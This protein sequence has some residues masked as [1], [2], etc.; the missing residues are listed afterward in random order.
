M[1]SPVLARLFR[2]RLWANFRSW[3]G[4][5]CRAGVLLT[6]LLVAGVACRNTERATDKLAAD[7][8]EARGSSS[9]TLSNITLEQPDEK[10]TL[11]WRVKA[12]QATYDRQSGLAQVENPR[13][14]LFQ[15][16]KVV[17]RLEAERADVEQDGERIF[18]RGK[19]TAIDIQDQAVLRGNEVEWRPKEDILVVRHQLSGTHPQLDIKAQEARAYS[20]KRRIELVG[21]IVAEAKNPVLQ[22]RAERAIW[23]LKQEQLTIGDQ[24]PLLTPPPPA[25]GNQTRSYRLIEIDR[26]QNEQDQNEQVTDR[27]RAQTAIVDLKRKIATLKQNV[28][29]TLQEPPLDVKGNLLV[30]QTQQQQVLADQ[31]VQIFHRQDRINLT[32]NRG[33]LDLKQEVATLTGNV[34]G[35]EPERQAKLRADRL[36][37][38]IPTQQMEAIGNVSYQ[39]ADPPLNLTGPRATGKFKD[40]AQTVVV[41]GGR[42]VTEIVPE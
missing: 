21:A 24:L 9:L 37:W 30:W 35:M 26:Y 39:Q 38:T 28:V 14:E 36:T 10:G 41:S 15:G 22:L 40:S 7:V 1:A 33:Q 6:L 13:G 23:E 17:Y 19:I 34:Y 12:D 32:A 18:L 31:P 5:G 2:A 4:V 8:E 20:R 42:V 25:P 11:L 27:A 29:L 3:L 16:G